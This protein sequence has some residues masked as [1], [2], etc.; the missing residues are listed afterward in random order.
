MNPQSIV[1]IQALFNAN[2]FSAYQWLAFVVCFV[3]V[4][5]D[6]FDAAVMGHIAPS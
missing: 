5:C 3:I 2:R 1:E 6:G 4:L